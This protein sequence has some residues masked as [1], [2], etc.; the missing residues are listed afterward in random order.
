VIAT[1]TG[2]LAARQSD[3]ATDCVPILF[4][5]WLAVSR[6]QSETAGLQ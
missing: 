1:V 2:D 3:F 4:M 5:H 6:L